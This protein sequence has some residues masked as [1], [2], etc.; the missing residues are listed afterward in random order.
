VR[1]IDLRKL[2]QHLV[3][4]GNLPERV[5]TDV[6]SYPLPDEKIAAAV[7]TLPKDGRGASVIVT[8]PERAVPLLKQAYA[9]AEKEAKAAY[10]KALAVL[11]SDA[12]LETLLA[13]ANSATAWD[14]GWN[15]KGM[16][17]FGAALSPLDNLLVALGHTRSRKAVP[18][19]IEKLQ[20]LDAEKEFSHHRAVGLALELIGDKSAARPLAELLAKPDM[21][22]HVQT[23]IA[24]ART[25]ETP[26]GVNAEQT[27]RESLREVM[28]AR[29]L[30]RCGD[31]EGVGEKI[32]RAYTQ[33]LRGH[34]AR[35]AA[36]ILAEKK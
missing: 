1:R 5:L 14:K 17:Q 23:D 30:Y 15:Y 7:A 29:A 6:D 16:G 4:I 9:Q 32:L 36:A 22:G 24:A 11:G 8:A 31:Y 33:D 21:M 3:E 2:Q 10:A 28:L 34:L 35:H 25:K 20:Q 13:E 27:R 12:G 19:I 26:G 18:A